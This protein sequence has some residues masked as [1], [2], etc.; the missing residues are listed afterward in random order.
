MTRAHPFTVLAVTAAWL[1]VAAEVSAQT[2]KDRYTTA[3]EREQSVRSSIDEVPA[4]T[5]TI[6]EL[7]ARLNRVVT[8]YE[9]LVRRFPTSGYADNALWQAANLADVGY[10]KFLKEEDRQ[11]ALRFYNWLIKEYPRSSL[12]AKA[13]RQITALTQARTPGSF[14]WD[15]TPSIVPKEMVPQYTGSSSY[16][17]LTKYNNYAGAGTG[18]GKNRIAILDPNDQTQ[19]DPVTASVTVMKEVITQLGPTPD[20]SGPPGSVKEWCVNTAAVDPF[21]RSVLVNSEDGNVYR[22]DLPSNTF[23]ERLAMNA[24]LAQSYTATA[25]GPD[26]RIYAINNAYLHSIG[27]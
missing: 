23:S 17:L 1:A 19:A 18:D 9:I 22:W 27:Q 5:S 15:N 24:G 21:T 3:M 2:A 11:R 26:G 25:I 6:G 20:P 14:G 4:D 7:L 16:L 12:V 10:Q 13:A 8:S